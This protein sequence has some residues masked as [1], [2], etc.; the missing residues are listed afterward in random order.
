MYRDGKRL[1]RLGSIEILIRRDAAKLVV[2]ARLEPLLDLVVFAK[3]KYVV[4]LK[5]L[6][7]EARAT[8]INSLRCGGTP[9]L[10]SR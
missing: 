1:E 8:S 6:A 7:E 9:D 5:G 2:V 4:V 10:R 3:A